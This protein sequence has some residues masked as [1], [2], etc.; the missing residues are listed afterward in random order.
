M[1]S[2]VLSLIMSVLAP[3]GCGQ[4]Q[5]SAP[6]PRVAAETWAFVGVHP[7]DPYAQRKANTM[8]RIAGIDA[9]FGPALAPDWSTYSPAFP[10][11][12]Y[13]DP[14]GY[15][16]VL[17]INAEAGM[18]T[19]VY[20]ARVWS[21][22]AGIRQKAI[23]FW[24]PHLPSIRAWDMGD[25]FD[26]LT[27]DWYILIERWAVVQTHI[28]PV[29]GVGPFTNNLGG[30]DILNAVLRDFPSQTTHYSF[31]AYAEDAKGYPVGLI[32]TAKH[33]APRVSHL[34]CAIN[35]LDHLHYTQTAEKMEMQMR[36]ASKVGCRSYLIFGGEKPWETPGFDSPSLV[37]W[38]GTPTPL[39]YAVARGA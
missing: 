17:K 9:T 18:K 38:D 36:E 33:A 34:M 2:V 29:T 26:P 5:S 24:W 3:L 35:A 19:I 12:R 16:R 10:G 31:D 37:N 14:E 21:S 13:L 39:A 7:D 11:E 6:V 27:P 25:E 4:T 20:D 8:G 22:D 32:D 15:L 23:D 28:T 1:K 30:L